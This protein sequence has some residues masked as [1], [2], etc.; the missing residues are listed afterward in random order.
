MPRD[1]YH[2]CP[3]CL[4]TSCAILG[5]FHGADWLQIQANMG[6]RPADLCRVQAQSTAKAKWARSF[7]R[8]YRWATWMHG[9]AQHHSSIIC[10]LPSGVA[11]QQAH[12]TSSVG[13]EP[14]ATQYTATFHSIASWCTYKAL[15]FL[16]TLG[17]QLRMFLRTLFGSL[18]ILGI[19]CGSRSQANKPTASPVLTSLQ[20]FVRNPSRCF[21]ILWQTSLSKACVTYTNAEPESGTVAVSFFRFAWTSFTDFSTHVWRVDVQ[22]CRAFMDVVACTYYIYIHMY[23]HVYIY[24]YVFSYT[25]ML[26]PLGPTFSECSSTW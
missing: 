17:L 25:Y 23:K 7:V 8:V 5:M 6:V 20:F 19:L 16:I 24:I 18:C 14:Y 11:D 26:A 3:L 1:G 21:K 10:A 4:P 13:R 12:F 9:A 15:V 22:M 2:C